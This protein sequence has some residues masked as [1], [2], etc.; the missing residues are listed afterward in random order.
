MNGQP[1]VPSP[2]QLAAAA[3][4]QGWN[5]GFN[6]GITLPENLKRMITPAMPVAPQ[7]IKVDPGTKGKTATETKD[8]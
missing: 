5:Q 2:E 7:G 1:P 4:Q 3:F 8:A 6:T